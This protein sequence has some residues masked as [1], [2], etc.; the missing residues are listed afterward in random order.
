MQWEKY[1][2]PSI[3]I[4]LKENKTLLQREAAPRQQARET[5]TWS[6]GL[7]YHEKTMDGVGVY[8]NQHV[9]LES[10]LKWNRLLRARLR[11]V[12]WDPW[13]WF[14]HQAP[15]G[16]PGAHRP[17][18]QR[19]QLVGIELQVHCL[20]WDPS[21]SGMP[22]LTGAPS[23]LE[24]C[25]FRWTGYSVASLSGLWS[26]SLSWLL[27]RSALNYCTLI[28]LLRFWGWGGRDW[29]TS[30]LLQRNLSRTR[31]LWRANL[32]YKHGMS[33]KTDV[34]PCWSWVIVYG[35]SLN[36]VN[37]KFLSKSAWLAVKYKQL[38]SIIRFTICC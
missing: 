27:L 9:S 28:S 23:W 7:L 34:D 1:G 8:V 38:L 13:E 15:S 12:A 37:R 31:A 21:L 6:E 19:R 3:N 32:D 25:F 29:E 18:A 17:G 36:Y 4:C 2:Y 26:H 16:W 5:D 35:G 10:K 22:L 24:H 30:L 33:G 11:E 14:L 20:P